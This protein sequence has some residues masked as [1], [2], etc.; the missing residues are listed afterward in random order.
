MWD[1][2]FDTPETIALLQQM[3]TRALRCMGGSLS[4]NYHWASDLTEGTDWPG[5]WQTS[6]ANFLHVATNIGAQVFTTVNYGTGSTNEAAAWVAYANGSV[7]NTL[8]L[9]VDQFGTN[10]GTVGYWA[11]LRAAA[12]LGQDDGTNFLRISRAAPLGFKYWEIGNECHG[13]WETDS[14]AV[15]HDP[16]TYA[17]RAR[18]YLNLMKAVD[19]T[20]KVGVVVTPGEGSYSN[21]A[22][23]FAVNP[24]TGSTNYGWTPILLINLARL[25]VTPDFAIH[26]SYASGDSDPLLLQAAGGVAGWASDAVSLRQMLSDYMGATG[27]N[28]E[29]CVTENNTSARGKQLTSLVNGLYYADSLSQLMQTEFNSFLWWDLRNGIWDDGNIDPTI[30]GWRLYGDEG[31]IG[32]LA[33][34]YPTFY[35]SKLMQYFA[36]PGD[37]VVSASSDYLLLSAYAVRGASGA[38]R[39]LVINKDTNADLNAQVAI[40]GLLPG[41]TTT[42]CSYGIPQDEAA[43]T[44]GTA[45]AQ[46]LAL[47]NFPSA[48]AGFSYSFPPLSLTLF[49]LAPTPP[50]LAMLPPAPQPGGQL[51]LQLQGQAGVRYVIDS[52]S[53]LTVWAPVLTNT[54]AGSTL[55]LTNSVPTGTAASFWRARWQP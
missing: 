6:F 14:N 55:N 50:R 54:L 22:N 52:S 13:T 23:H 9:G 34:C 12:P 43:R 10:W 33:T 20:I 44:Y 2:Y 41:A 3:G 25:G 11:S 15:P 51:V 49:T 19:G 17:T 39:A 5:P 40:S 7:T 30:Y 4:D 48:S 21:N 27:T 37:T 35:A 42:I 45:E 29:L 18:D 46:D 32:G 36:Q 16:Y 28:V 8:A 1:A 38:V 24:R 31:V 47:T 53:D 26:H